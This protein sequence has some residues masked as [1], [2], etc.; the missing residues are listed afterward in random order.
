MNFDIIAQIGIAVYGLTAIWLVNSKSPKAQ[1]WAS[2]F[3]LGG[4]PF[5]FYVT[6]SSAQWGMF[7]LCICYTIA[8]GRGFY[9]AWIEKK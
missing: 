2:V 1:R 8:W 7:A 4:Q 5:W 9:F 6:Y 3:G